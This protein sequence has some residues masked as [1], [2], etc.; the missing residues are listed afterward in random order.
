MII[1]IYKPDVS[2]NAGGGRPR[3]AYIDLI[4][5]VLEKVRCVVQPACVYDQVASGRIVSAY[6]NRK[7][8]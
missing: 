1:S 3:R 5:E 2:G 7:K 8:A 4:G 6:P